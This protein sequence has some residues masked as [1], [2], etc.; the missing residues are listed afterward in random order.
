MWLLLFQKG[1]PYFQCLEITTVIPCCKLL[2][3]L[4]AIVPSRGPL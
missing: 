2:L 3:L 1:V 4:L